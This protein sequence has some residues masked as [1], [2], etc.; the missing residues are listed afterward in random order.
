ML[1]AEKKLEQ[2]LR[3]AARRGLSLAFVEKKK[4]LVRIECP[5][6]C[7]AR[8]VARNEII[9]MNTFM[10]KAGCQAPSRCAPIDLEEGRVAVIGVRYVS[11]RFYMYALTAGL[12]MNELC[13]V[14]L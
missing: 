8:G 3:A 5:A 6:A 4:E 14:K 12:L 2:R 9:N 1:A 10:R 7:T 11:G 13:T